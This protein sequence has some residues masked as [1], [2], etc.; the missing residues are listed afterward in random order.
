MG[1]FSNIN[2][3]L[4][5]EEKETVIRI[6][7]EDRSASKALEIAVNAFALADK[8][9]EC[10]ESEPP[11]LPRPI[12]CREGC[13]FCCFN[14]VE[15]TPPEALI[16]GDYVDRTFTAEGKA[17]LMQ[18]LDRAIR[19]KHGKSKLEVACLRK[20]LRCPLL[21]GGRCA[22]YEVR[23]LV[24]RA[25]HSLDVG[26]CEQALR[27]GSNTGVEHYCHRDEVAGSILKG[28]MEGCREMGCQAGPLD[29]ARALRDFS[30]AHR[31]SEQWI[32]GKKTFCPLIYRRE[33]DNY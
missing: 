19:F 12:A 16:I 30:D 22:V 4:A 6:I 15:I 21:R 17:V 7:R 13:H 1:L 5:R 9:I 10:V 33:D 23:P 25:I 27:V 31:P 20:E 2:E 8:S 26:Q 14:Q 18:N 3:S 29:L 11:P 32:V 24:C 28:L